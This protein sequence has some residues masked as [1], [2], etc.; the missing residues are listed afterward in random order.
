MRGENLNSV[1]QLMKKIL[2]STPHQ[3]KEMTGKKKSAITHTTAG[4]RERET[5]EKFLKGSQLLNSDENIVII[6]RLSQVI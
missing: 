1:N 3:N 2:F 6:S 4:G 5:I